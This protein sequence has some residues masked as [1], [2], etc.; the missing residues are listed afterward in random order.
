MS[1]KI[2]IYTDGGSRGNPGPAGI[3]VWVE[4]LNKKYGEGTV[5]VKIKDQYYN[6]VEKI[7]EKKH[8]VDTAYKAME[9]CNITPKVVPIRGGTDGARLSFLGLPT[10]NLFTG[11]HNF[12]GRYE[13]IP[14]PSMEKSVEV[15]LKIISLYAEN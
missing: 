2:L 12:H 14:V 15:I 7:N 4:T 10:P 5:E 6:M 8:I 13:Y 1:E 3:G 11:G 9:E